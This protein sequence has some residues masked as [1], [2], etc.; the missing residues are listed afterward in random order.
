MNFKKPTRAAVFKRFDKRIHYEKVS[1]TEDKAAGYCLKE[2]TRLEGPFEFG[3][4][5]VR[6][7][8]KADWDEVRKHAIAGDL[9]KIPSHIFVQHYGNLRAVAKDYAIK[10]PECPHL[11]GIWI[12]GKTGVGK[13]RYA[14]KHWPDYY[15]K[16]C[17]KWWDGYQGEANVIMDDI[18]PEHNVL[19]TYMKHW[20]DHQQCGL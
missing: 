5:P 11:R 6:R 16:D 18:A 17:N 13:S 3:I 10:G 9:E 8:S 2:E 1:R 20:A 14:R 4:K 12:Y 19:A 7:S 15:A